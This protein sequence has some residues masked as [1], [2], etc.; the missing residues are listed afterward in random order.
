LVTSAQHSVHAQISFGN[1]RFAGHVTQVV[2]DRYDDGS[3]DDNYWVGTL[4]S[5]Y[6]Q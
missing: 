5:T 2:I 6:N 3:I 4:T 1:T